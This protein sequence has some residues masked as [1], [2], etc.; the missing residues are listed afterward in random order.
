L[1]DRKPRRRARPDL[2]N[3]EPFLWQ[4][5]RKS[6]PIAKTPWPPRVRRLRKAKPAATSTRRPNG[7]ALSPRSPFNGKGQRSETP[8]HSASSQNRTAFSPRNRK[9]TTTSITPSG[10]T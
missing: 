9:N 7:Q 4:Q 8:P 10:R 5:K 2:E 6:S 3:K 1:S